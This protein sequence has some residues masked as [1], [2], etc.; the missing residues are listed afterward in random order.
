MDQVYYLLQNWISAEPSA[1]L[2]LGIASVLLFGLTYSRL[3][4][5]TGYSLWR[6]L[7]TALVNSLVLIALAVMSYS[8]LDSGYKAFFN[9]YGPFVASGTVSNR[10]WN[11]ARKAYGGA[12]DQ[13]DLQ[14]MQYV[15]V[16]TQQVVQPA[17]AQDPPLYRNVK[18]E[19]LLDQNSINGFR[20]KV[21]VDVTANDRSDT[22]NG[23]GLNADYEY[24]IVNPSTTEVRAEFRFPVSF[25]TKVYKDISITANGKEVPWRMAGN[26]IY[27]EG[28]MVPGEKQVVSIKFSALGLNRFQFAI[29]DQHLITKF[30]LVVTVNTNEYLL[31]TEPANGGIQTHIEKTS[32]GSAIT[33]KIDN[34]IVSPKLGFSLIQGWPF[35]PRQEMLV[36]LPY[37]GRASILFLALVVL[38]LVICNADVRLPSLAFLSVLFMLPFLLLM[39]GV[40]PHPVWVTSAQLADYQVKMLP[41]IT[42]LSIVLAFFVMRRSPRLPF[43]LILVFMAL[44]IGGYPLIGLL[45]EQKGKSIETLVQ[46]GIIAYV[47]LLT[48]ILRLRK[49]GEAER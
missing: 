31:Q 5:R 35:A 2:W 12:Y 8:L 30:S 13:Q 46:V 27:W 38:T 14:V 1:I 32:Q 34:A 43:V 9:V 33:W 24:D 36:I 10:G 48:L 25:E 26:A 22:F 18:V 21:N 37:A 17:K 44:F 40:I 28:P 23:F 16:I 29:P 4:D 3:K 39:S 15:T 41:V 49:V 11:V 47:F 45:D 20:G 19:Q 42:L 6:V 7:L